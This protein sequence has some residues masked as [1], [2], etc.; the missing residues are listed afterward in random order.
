MKALTDKEQMVMNVLWEHRHCGVE[1]VLQFLPEP[2][3]A[4]NTILTFLRILEQKGFI[5]YEAKGKKHIYYPI[6]EKGE[7]T[8]WT[9]TDMKE[10][11]FDGSARSMVNTF[12]MESGL[13]D[14]DV[15]ELI[16]MLNELETSKI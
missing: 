16:S 1:D 8:R 5:F 3:P 6:V 15:R 10:K 2:K 12:I 9:L 7:Y 4:Y 13:T 14:S 11:L